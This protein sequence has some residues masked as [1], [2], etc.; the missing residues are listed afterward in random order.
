M[1]KDYRRDL[2]GLLR[3][4]F[5]FDSAD[6]DFGIYRIMN[7]KRDEIER[8]IERDLIEAVDAEFDKYLS[9]NK[10]VLERELEELKRKIASTL[11]EN[12]LSPSGDLRE[13]YRDLTYCQGVQQEER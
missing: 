8:F 10:L 3:R 7:Y 11:G 4:L 1:V 6:L 12:A 9:K 2:Q 13:M 5:Q